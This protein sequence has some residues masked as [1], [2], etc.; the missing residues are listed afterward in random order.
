MNFLGNVSN[1]SGS[2]NPLIKAA[3]GKAKH[4]GTIGALGWK[5]NINQQHK[6]KGGNYGINKD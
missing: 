5:D 4:T 6:H 3:P 1:R 2:W